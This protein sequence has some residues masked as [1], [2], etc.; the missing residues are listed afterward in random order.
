MMLLQGDC[1]QELKKIPAASVDII[2]AD[3]PY[4]IFKHLDWDTSISNFDEFWSQVW[5]VSKP[6]TPV[7]LFG[8]FKF[9][10]ELIRSQPKYFKYELVWNKGK[11]TSPLQSQMRMGSAT[12]Y[13]CVFYKNPPV[14]NYKTY[15]K[16]FKRDKVYFNGTIV[17]ADKKKKQTNYYDPP[18]PLNIIDCP[19]KMRGKLIKNITEKPQGILEKILKYHSNEG[20][21]C[22]DM[23][24]GS[25]S[26]GVACHNLERKFIGIEL[27]QEHFNI[28]KKRL[29][30]EI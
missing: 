7:F 10:C 9:A 11:S 16:V 20:D 22:L 25:G 3:L 19:P 28:A 14:Y 18:L 17:G 23:C 5:R 13:V 26:C 21:T 2:L 29:N 6:N 4:N 12:E 30:F 24:M 8:N 27:N 15:H 1:L